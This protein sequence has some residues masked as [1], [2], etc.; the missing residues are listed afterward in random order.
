ME[1][2][3]KAKQKFTFKVIKP[4][5]KAGTRL[6]L[7]EE[8]EISHEDQD[9]LVRGG[10]VCPSDLPETGTYIVL[11]PFFLPGREGKFEAKKLEKV[12]L[13]AADALPLMIS[14]SVIPA[15]ENQWR[16]NNRRLQQAPAPDPKKKMVSTSPRY[17]DA[18]APVK[19]IL[20]KDCFVK[21]EGKEVE[22]VKGD[23]AEFT[24]YLAAEIIKAKCGT[25][26]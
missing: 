6:A 16:P 22:Y 5:M 2:I 9:G 3:K 23:T 13:R 18:R 21:I 15:N 20:T 17:H 8:V 4:F 11:K 10:R 24:P 19:M 1:I 25:L 14:A 7:G 12:L 26:A